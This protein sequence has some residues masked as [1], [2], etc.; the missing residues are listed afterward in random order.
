MNI[1]DLTK[2]QL[3]LLT[4]LVN[5][6]TSI[7][8]GVLTVSLLDSAPPSVTRTVNQIVERSVETVSET[9]PITIIQPAKPTPVVTDEEMLTSAISSAAL[10]AVSISSTKPGTVPVA[11]GVYFSKSRIV[12]TLVGPSLPKEA[13]ITFA[14]GTTVQ[15][16]LSRK[17]D[18][19][20]V[21][22]FADAAV[23]PEAP[24]AARVPVASL[25]QGQTVVALT[26]DRSAA[27][28]IISKVDA[29]G[30]Y[31]TLPG[32]PAGSAA[33]N[34]SGDVIGLSSGTAGVFVSAELISSLLQGTTTTA[35]DR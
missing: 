11:V 30:I 15:A 27:T 2:S 12:A 31:T 10:R 9:T 17:G 21:Y 28:G 24:S 34:L 23:L 7:A 33:V 20:A 35:L 29:S 5:F 3:L 16:S 22:G 32:V 25:K 8:T 13:V 19:V 4:V 26:N 18:T 1:E 6:I 14:D